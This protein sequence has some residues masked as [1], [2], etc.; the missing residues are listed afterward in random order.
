MNKPTKWGFKLWVLADSRTGYNWDMVVYTGKSR[1]NDWDDFSVI[2]NS[3]EGIERGLGRAKSLDKNPN[4]EETGNMMNQLAARV[5][6]NLTKPL[7]NMGYVLFVDNFYTSIPLFQYLASVGINAVGTIRENSTSF[8]NE[9]KN[10]QSWGEKQERGAI[11]YIRLG[12][13]PNDVLLLQWVDRNVVSVASTYHSAN[14]FDFCE[15]NTKVDGN[16][17]KVKVLRPKCIS[18]YNQ[19]M[20]SVDLSDQM[21]RMYSV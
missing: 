13:E 15:R 19:D 1:K 6:I 5:V 7:I 12:D 4:P 11:R 17:R 18:D 10:R 2:N 20:N 9:M 14:D 3:F 16:Y 21:C 8:P